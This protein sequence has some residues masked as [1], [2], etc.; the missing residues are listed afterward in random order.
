MWGVHDLQ[1][2]WEQKSWKEPPTTHLVWVEIHWA[3]E[4]HKKKT[5]LPFS[6]LDKT[7]TQH[8]TSQNKRF[9]SDF[10]TPLLPHS[11]QQIFILKTSSPH[12]PHPKKATFRLSKILNFPFSE[13]LLYFLALGEF[14]LGLYTCT[15]TQLFHFLAPFFFSQRKTCLYQAPN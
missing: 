9:C 4:K 1:L 5:K 7:K 13:V 15:T 10:T 11:F 2:I 8:H 12:P 14:Y 6:C 3:K